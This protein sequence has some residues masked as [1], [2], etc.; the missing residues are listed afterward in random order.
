MKKIHQITLR[1]SGPLMFCIALG[2]CITAEM[3]HAAWAVWVPFAWGCIGWT[4]YLGA[5]T[6]IKQHVALAGVSLDR[7]QR[8]LGNVLDAAEHVQTDVQTD[9]SDPEPATDG[10]R[11]A[12]R[13]RVLYQ[14][15]GY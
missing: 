5:K 13:A 3:T 15:G 14:D 9:E 10:A 4:A 2:S 6:A 1:A 12:A 8:A 7:L 11:A